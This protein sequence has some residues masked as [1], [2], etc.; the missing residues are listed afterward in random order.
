MPRRKSLKLSTPGEVRKALARIANMLI[1]GEIEAKEANSIILC[2]N[3]ILGAMKTC[4]YEQKL[5]ELER[6]LGE[7][8]RQAGR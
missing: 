3:A 2:C 4:D 5:L 6:L 1:N 8:E 7:A